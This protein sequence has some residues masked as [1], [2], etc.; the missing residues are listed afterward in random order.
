[1]SQE[2]F[3][4][5]QEQ[6]GAYQDPL[7]A[8]E[9]EKPAKKKAGGSTVAATVV[10]VIV[11]FLFGAI[12]GLICYGGYWAVFA[13]AKSKLPV[14]AKVILGVLVSIVFLVLLIAFILFSAAARASIN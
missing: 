4:S 7:A 5:Q 14:A 12:G 9:N 10:A 8:A 1:M 11:F 2:Q 13:I 6:A 3:N